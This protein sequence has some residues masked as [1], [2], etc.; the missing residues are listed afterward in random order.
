MIWLLLLVF[1]YLKGGKKKATFTA[2]QAQNSLH[3]LHWSIIKIYLARS[4]LQERL[5]K[6]CFRQSYCLL[7]WKGKKSNRTGVL[8]SRVPTIH[9][10]RSYCHQ[11]LRNLK[12]WN[13]KRKKKTWEKVSVRDHHHPEAYTEWSWYSHVYQSRRQRFACFCYNLKHFNTRFS[14]RTANI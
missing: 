2:H 3:L 5:N 10:S 6:A 7:T 14:P 13:K 4:S 9:F 11:S 12:L 8:V 1:K